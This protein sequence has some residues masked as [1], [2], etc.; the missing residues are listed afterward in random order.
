MIVSNYTLNTLGEMTVRGS[1][2][3]KGPLEEL[4]Q[5]E[6]KQFVIATGNLRQHHVL[7]L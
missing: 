3:N 6:A 1:V 5:N 7:A 2:G 4:Q